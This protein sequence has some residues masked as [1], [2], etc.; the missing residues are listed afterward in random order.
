M[1]IVFLDIGLAHWTGYEL[2][3]DAT[4]LVGRGDSAREPLTGINV[5]PFCTFKMFKM[6]FSVSNPARNFCRMR[7][8]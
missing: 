6:V 2:V 8:I 3:L 7:L 1:D 4:L 5:R